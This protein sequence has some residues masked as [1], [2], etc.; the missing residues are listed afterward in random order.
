ML[1]ELPLEILRLI[2]THLSPE[3]S[4]CFAHSC[5]NTY[6]ACDDWT[7]WRVI[8]SGSVHSTKAS[9]TE[10]ETSIGS[11]NKMAGASVARRKEDSCKRTAVEQCMPQL[12][13]PGR[14]CRDLVI[15]SKP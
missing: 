10:L 7:I 4:L 12:M 2:R 6:H 1:S 8:V 3:A 14:K 15:S 9:I 13:V 11:T 5:K